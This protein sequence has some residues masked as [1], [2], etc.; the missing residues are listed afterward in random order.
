MS[1]DMKQESG[2][3]MSTVRFR[4][5]DVYSQNRDNKN[6]SREGWDNKDHSPCEG[7]NIATAPT[8]QHG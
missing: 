6:C 1:P 3:L 5:A 7:I 4:T 8:G 2:V